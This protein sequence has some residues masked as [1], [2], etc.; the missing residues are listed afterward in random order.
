[1]S[2]DHWNCSPTCLIVKLVRFC[3][4]T[5]I[6]TRCSYLL[7]MKCSWM[8]QGAVSDLGKCLALYLQCP[9]WLMHFTASALVSNWIAGCSL[10]QPY[11][12][13]SLHL[14]YYMHRFCSLNYL[15]HCHLQ[16]THLF[17][18]LGPDI[19]VV[20]SFHWCA[21]LYCSGDVPGHHGQCLMQP[22]CVWAHPGHLELFVVS[23]PPPFT[24]VV[25]WLVLAFLVPF[26]PCSALPIVSWC[27]QHSRCICFDIHC[28]L[29]DL[30]GL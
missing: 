12:T 5:S 18:L 21:C 25:P 19:D 24:P 27:S 7:L 29:L 13:L 22:F 14:W 8:S 15:C 10:H 1:M 23:F 30:G 17:A 6:S 2:F 3:Q 9:C 28:S 4:C 16:S 20:H 11:S 26:W